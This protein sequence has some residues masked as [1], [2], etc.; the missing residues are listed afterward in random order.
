M[1]S[2]GKPQSNAT[3]RRI[4]AYCHDSVGVG[5]L[6]RTLAI[7]EHVGRLHPEA[8]FFLA[9]GTP[10]VPLF[11]R[12]PRVD[13][14]KLPALTKTPDGS[15]SSK[16]LNLPIDTVIHC[17]EA[18]L[19]QAAKHYQPHVL[20]VDKA[21]LGVCRELVPTLQWFKRVYSQTRIVFGMRDIE[22]D[23]EAT[24]RQWDRDGVA[25][26]L[27]ECFDEVWV[28]GMAELFDPVVE[29]RLPDSVRNKVRFMGYV[30]RGPCGHR[31]AATANSRN[32]LVTVGGG[33]DGEALLDA[34]LSETAGRVASLGIRSTVVGGPD[35]PEPAAQR[36]RRLAGQLDRVEWIDFEPCMSCR[37]AQAELVVSMGGYNTLCEVARRR[38]P[39][40]IIP[41]IKPRLEQAIRARLWGRFGG[42]F[43]LHPSDLT[44]HSMCERV[45]DL[46]ERGPK[47]ANTGLKMNGLDE[48]ARRFDLFWR[49][50]SR[51]A[52]A[53]CL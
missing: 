19:L 49:E 5:H 35:L 39:A 48:V 29:Y 8:S 50:D 15:Y 11:Q 33:T 44:P 38:K 14:I 36:L 6:R 25:E 4:M 22:D 1:N 30:A 20:L 23:P 47:V 53:V 42:I 7:S 2:L 40:L 34:Y 41:R 26:V 37:I 27:A 45:I 10:Y 17:R 16:F 51:H 24:I 32:V 52:S 28:Y 18:L 43:P 31:L 13:Y 12:V 21:P 3:P 9:T 46:L